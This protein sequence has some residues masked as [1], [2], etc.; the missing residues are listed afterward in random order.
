MHG[1]QNIKNERHI[2]EEEREDGRKILIWMVDK[3]N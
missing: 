1:Q 3:Y 2:L